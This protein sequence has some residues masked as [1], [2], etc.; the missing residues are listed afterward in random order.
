[1]NK[2]L[3]ISNEALQKFGYG[4][5][6]NMSVNDFVK[7]AQNDIYE[8]DDGLLVQVVNSLRVNLKASESDRKYN[9]YKTIVNKI[10]LSHK[11]MYFNMKALCEKADI[12]YQTYRNWKNSF[13]SFSDLK[14]NKLLDCMM[15]ISNEIVKDINLNKG[16]TEMNE[17]VK[18]AMN[19]METTGYK[20]YLPDLE[21]GEL[22]EINDVWDGKG[23]CPEESYSYFITDKG[24]DDENIEIWLNYEFEIIEVC[25]NNL[26]N[27]IKITNIE[28]I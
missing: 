3:Y 8:T 11:S 21:V 2:K 26:N 19:I 22:C 6:Y 12:S 7:E 5:F 17:I 16:R 15:E 24:E 20:G 14:V 4:Y 28:L 25:D 9:E 18:E 27:V 1:M 10:T 13:T 23:E